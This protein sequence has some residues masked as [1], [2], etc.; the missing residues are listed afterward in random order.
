MTSFWYWIFVPAHIRQ[1]VCIAV[2]DLFVRREDTSSNV[3][4]RPLS[5][6]D[7]CLYAFLRGEKNEE[8]HRKN[9]DDT[10]NTAFNI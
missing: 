3:D 9:A 10:K 5:G 8:V 6:T 2:L 7:F 4:Q 1:D